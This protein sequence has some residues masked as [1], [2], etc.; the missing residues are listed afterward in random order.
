LLLLRHH[1]ITL[2]PGG[3]AGDGDA[4][5]VP[6][7]RGSSLLC[8]FLV[9]HHLAVERKKDVATTGVSDVD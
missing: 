9:P 8:P 3:T 4:A 7:R 2:H 5:A 1:W 6:D